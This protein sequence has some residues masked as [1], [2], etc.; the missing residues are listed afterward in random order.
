MLRP[1]YVLSVAKKA[2]REMTGVRA[3]A[4]GRRADSPALEG[5]GRG[6]GQIRGVRR[7]GQGEGSRGR[8]KRIN[9]CG[10]RLSPQRHEAHCS[11]ILA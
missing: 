6:L 11:P 5:R 8:V 7:T 9:R 1:Y 2:F 3:A 4:A 10:E